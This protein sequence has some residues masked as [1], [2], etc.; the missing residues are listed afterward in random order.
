MFV[1]PELPYRY[2][3]L[4]PAM[5]EDTLRTHHGKHHRKYVETV[6]QLL[7]KADG[8]ADTME[9]VVVEAARRGETKLFNNAG[10]A[11]NHGFFWNSMTPGGATLAGPVQEAVQQAYGGREG[12]KARFVEEGVAHF[13]SGWIWLVA[14]DGRLDL[15]CTHDG[16]CILTR[17]QMKPLL[18]CDLWEHAY[19]LDHRNDRKAFLEGW[20]D[21]LANWDFAA[22][23]LAG[24]MWRYPER[25]PELA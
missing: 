5:S 11:W 16:D 21:R 25:T 24:Q 12:L 10:Q 7:E 17:P 20:F 23:Q 8:R 13:G 4:T 2:D 15:V 1:L 6:N 18:V 14:D 3:A 22:R 9:Q 19:Y